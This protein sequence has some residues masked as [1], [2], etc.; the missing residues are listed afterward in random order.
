[1]TRFVFPHPNAEG[2][3]RI[4]KIAIENEDDERSTPISRRANT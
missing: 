4:D 1:M 2:L 3:V